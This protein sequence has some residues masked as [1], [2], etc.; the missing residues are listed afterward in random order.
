MNHV[1]IATLWL[2]FLLQ[3][4]GL[5][6]C[7]CAWVMVFKNIIASNRKVGGGPAGN[8]SNRKVGGDPAPAR[9]ASNE[10]AEQTFTDSVVQKR[11][12]NVCEF[13][14]MP[15]SGVD[16]TN[17]QEVSD[18]IARVFDHSFDLPNTSRSG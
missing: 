4:A 12:R 2:V 13:F 16:V 18:L 10:A 8:A 6:V 1:T 9:Y 7:V 14:P 15:P 3:A 11:D 17:P 5:A